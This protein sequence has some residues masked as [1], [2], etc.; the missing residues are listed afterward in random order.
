M[1][2]MPIVFWISWPVTKCGAPDRSF[3]V[4]FSMAGLLGTLVAEKILA[5]LE[6]LRERDA[7]RADIA[8]GTAFEAVNKADG[9]STIEIIGQER[10]IQQHRPKPCGTGI[11]ATAA[12]DALTFL[13]LS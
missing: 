8:A 2:T 12:A 13:V 4:L 1:M 11:C 9:I 10:G 7:C 5:E 6:P 3:I